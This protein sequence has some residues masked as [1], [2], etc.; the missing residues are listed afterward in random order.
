M[1]WTYALKY[2]SEKLNELKVDGDGIT[3]MEKFSGTTTDINLKNH[4]IWGCTVCVLG[5][6]FQ[7][8]IAGL[9]KWEPLSRSVVYLGH[10]PFHAGAVALVLNPA[11]GHV[12]PQFHVVFYDE[13]STIPFMS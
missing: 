2:F 7:G 5:A 4:H 8:I 1:L 10:S 9:T 3:P 6:R 12:S 13:F 11:T